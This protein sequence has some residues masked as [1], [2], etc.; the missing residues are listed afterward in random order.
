MKVFTQMDE[1]TFVLSM[2]TRKKSLEYNGI[3]SFSSLGI[4]THVMCIYLRASIS[5]VVW[6]LRYGAIILPAIRSA[7]TNHGTGNAIAFYKRF[8]SIYS[9]DSRPMNQKKYLCSI[10]HAY[11]LHWCT[12][13][14]RI[15]RSSTQWRL[16]TVHRHVSFFSLE[17]HIFTAY[18]YIQICFD[19]ITY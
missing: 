18:I 15:E 5:C 14:L 12:H 7:N 17:A 4:R 9:I 16:S 19:I 2:C 10:K 6:S 11:C 3:Q 13:S 8:L 1:H